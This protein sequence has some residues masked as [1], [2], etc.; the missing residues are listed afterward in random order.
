MDQ[1]HD[2][3]NSLYGRR[4]I[5]YYPPVINHIL[6]F[7]AI[8][9]SEF[10]EI[11]N[12][13]THAHS[14]LKDAYLPTMGEERIQSWE[15]ILGILPIEGSTLD[16]RRETII[17]RIRGQ[18]KLNTSLINSIVNAFTGGTA[19]SYIKNSVLYNRLLYKRLLTPC[20]PFIF[21]GLRGVKATN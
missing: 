2:L 9:E 19:N 8:I 7:R 12:L 21:K 16:D 14:A 13:H 1:P 4:M 18:G 20:K 3:S 10:P 6:E 15:K 5:N 17:A 11:E